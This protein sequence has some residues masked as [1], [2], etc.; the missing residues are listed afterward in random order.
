MSES[1]RDFSTVEEAPYITIDGG[2]CELHVRLDTYE[3]LRL[4]DLIQ[5]Q[6]EIYQKSR[7]ERTD[8][9]GDR[10]GAV[11]KQ[12]TKMIVD[13]TDDQNDLLDSTQRTAILGIHTKEL[14]KRQD[15]TT[16]GE[17]SPDSPD[18]TDQ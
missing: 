10:L 11:M 5:E 1:L 13:I 15:P 8:E 16:A 17:T 2:K 9:D 7:D 3:V 14:G 6:Q 12:I 18:S 4:N